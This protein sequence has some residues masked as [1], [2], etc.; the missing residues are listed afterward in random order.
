MAKIPSAAAP[1]GQHSACV[2]DTVLAC[3]HPRWECQGGDRGHILEQQGNYLLS[4]IL[5]HRT[6]I[7]QLPA[8]A[9]AA[10]QGFWLGKGTQERNRHQNT[11]EHVGAERV[12]GTGITGNRGHELLGMK[13]WGKTS[14]IRIL[15]G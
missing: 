6:S 9:A 12:R 1:W 7:S 14:T 8:L 3:C 4:S 10:L 13:N 15:P 5:W 2:T 11:P